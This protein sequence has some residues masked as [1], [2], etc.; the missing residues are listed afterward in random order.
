MPVPTGKL[1]AGASDFGIT[2]APAHALEC[3]GFHTDAVRQLD[4]LETD[5]KAQ[6]VQFGVV[7]MTGR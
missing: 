3:N 1:T 4:L 6:L 5:F 2:K 7:E